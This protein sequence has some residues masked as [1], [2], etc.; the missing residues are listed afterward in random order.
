MGDLIC[1][2]T[3]QCFLLVQL[4][5]Q[6]QQ[7]THGTPVPTK[8]HELCSCCKADCCR[9]QMLST[10]KKFKVTVV[11]EVYLAKLF[12]FLEET[13]PVVMVASQQSTLF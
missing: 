4:L 11:V 5:Q 12:L 13:L 7:A 9:A 10:P 8:T 6:V 2:Q 3:H 1:D